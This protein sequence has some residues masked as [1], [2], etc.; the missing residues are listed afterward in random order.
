MRPESTT[1]NLA[2][3]E[4]KTKTTIA[5]GGDTVVLIQDLHV[6]DTRM[7]TGTRRLRLIIAGTT[8]M[9]ILCQRHPIHVTIHI[10][11]DTETQDS[12]PMIGPTIVPTTHHLRRF[13]AAGLIGT[14][15]VPGTRTIPSPI[16]LATGMT[17]MMM[18]CLERPGQAGTM[19]IAMTA[20]RISS[21]TIDIIMMAAAAAGMMMTTC[22]VFLGA[23]TGAMM[24]AVPL[25]DLWTT[26]SRGTHVAAAI[27]MMCLEL[28]V[29]IHM[30]IQ[31]MCPWQVSNAIQT[32]FL[33]C[34]V[35][36]ATQEA[37]SV[38]LERIITAI[39]HPIVATIMMMMMSQEQVATATIRI[40]GGMK[41]MNV[42]VMTP[43]VMMMPCLPGVTIPGIATIIHHEICHT[44]IPFP[45]IKPIR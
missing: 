23:V 29:V 44:V 3:G 21:P 14:T 30:T 7:T 28:A 1:S 45:R 18:T 26:M 11:T 19:M 22:V 32:M 24:E 17:I 6:D 40:K 13:M 8:M 36:A 42:P 27:Q 2:A 15:V 31:K 37:C 43:V 12:R 5:L 38:R 34:L 20:R 39:I 10:T 35:P 4:E 16:R 33:S 25:V 9:A 41:R